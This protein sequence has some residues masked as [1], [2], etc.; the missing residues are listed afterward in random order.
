VNLQTSYWQPDKRIT[1]RGISTTSY[2][3]CHVKSDSVEMRMLFADKAVRSDR[4][5]SPSPHWIHFDT[6]SDWKFGGMIPG[7]S[8]IKGRPADLSVS[9]LYHAKAVSVSNTETLHQMRPQKRILPGSRDTLLPFPDCATASVSVGYPPTSSLCA[10]V[11]K[12]TPAHHVT[13]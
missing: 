8:W 4:F 3:I 1:Q 11:V 12:S 7:C 6:Q 10:I 5:R 9:V 13:I 2:N